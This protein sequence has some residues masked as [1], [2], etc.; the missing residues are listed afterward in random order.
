M[1]L[2]ARMQR[3]LGPV[4][5]LATL[6]VIV[7]SSP[8]RAQVSIP[9]FVTSLNQNFNTLASSGTSTALPVGWHLLESGSG[10][11]ATYTASDGSA[12]TGDTYSFGRTAR[13]D[14]LARCCH[15]IR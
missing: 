13:T 7:A 9:S 12:S 14:N 2:P 1:R 5:T 8:A 11:D 15:S 10:A 6:V 3:L 4:L